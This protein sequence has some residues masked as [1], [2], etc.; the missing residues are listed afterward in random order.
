MTYS[1]ANLDKFVMLVGM[2]LADI[3]QLVLCA[4]QPSL[5]LTKANDKSL[6]FSF[7]RNLFSLN[8]NKHIY[9]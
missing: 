8:L 6:H 4:L 9:K 5:D 2:K 1:V 3:G 7:F